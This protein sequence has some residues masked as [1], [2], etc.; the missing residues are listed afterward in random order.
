MDKTVH[1]INKSGEIELTKSVSHQHPSDDSKNEDGNLFMVSIKRK[2]YRFINCGEV[3][4]FLGML[5]MLS[6]FMADSWTLGN[7]VAA[8]FLSWWPHAPG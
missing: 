7:A 4:L 5:L 3:Q 1:P 6:L 8:G 2:V